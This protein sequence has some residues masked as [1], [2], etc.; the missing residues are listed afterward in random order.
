[1]TEFIL[2][3]I[4]FT[5]QGNWAVSTAYEKDD[6]V[7]YGGNTYVCTTGHTSA[8]IEADFYTDIAKWDVHVEGVTHKGDHATA[9]F[10]KLNDIVKS[11]VSQYICTTQHTST[12]TINLANFTL[13]VLGGD[14]ATQSGKSGQFLSTDGTNTSWVDIVEAAPG[15]L[16]TLNELAASL[17]DDPDFAGTITTALAGKEP[18]LTAG[19]TTQ[20][21]RGDKTWQTL[22]VDPTMGGDMSGTTSNAQIVPGAVDTAEM[23]NDAVNITKLNVT[24]GTSGQA[25]MTDGS[26]T[27]TFGDVDA[28][29]T[30]TSNAGKFLTTDGTDSSWGALSVSAAA[31][32]DQA[33]TATGYFDVPAGTTAQRPGTPLMGNMRYNST[34]GEMEQYSGSGWIG[35]AGSV[36]IIT[37]IGPSTAAETG[38]TI[39]INGANFSGS[40]TVQLIGTDNSVAVP[41]T[42]TFVDVN[43]LSITTPALTVAN[44]PYDVKV[45]N[46]DGQTYTLVNSLDAGGVP[47]WTTAA[48]SIGTMLDVV[49]TPGVT[50]FTLV[51]GDP[52]STAVT[53][54]ETTS[55]LA[56]AGL[57]LNSTT[58]AITG[59]APT[60]Q[61]TN[62]ATTYNFDVEASDGVNT[63]PRS[64]SVT[65]MDMPTGGSSTHVYTSTGQGYRSHVFNSSSSFYVAADI[66][67]DI[68]VVAGGGAGGNYSTTNGNGGGGAG[69]MVVAD[70]QLITSGTHGVTIGGGGS[71]TGGNTHSTGN[72]GSD[73]T[74]V[75]TTNLQAK[76]GGG[77]GTSGGPGPGTNG[78]CGGGGARNYTGG[79]SIQDSQGTQ[80]NPGTEIAVWGFKGGSGSS[81]DWNGSGGGGTGEAGYGYL[82]SGNDSASSG[83]A[84]GGNGGAG[85]ICDLAEGGPS[86]SPASTTRWFAGGGGG[87]GNSSEHAGDGYHGGGRG[88]GTTPQ[89]NNDQWPD[90]VNSTTLGHSNIHAIINTGAGGGGGS[91]WAS[92]IS[93]SGNVYGSGSGASGIIIIRYKSG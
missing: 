80:N 19:T 45:T 57:S 51:A 53:Y 9:T 72:T 8:A 39:T 40:S 25:L 20:Y 55:V 37:S 64:F 47:A 42:V 83:Q 6:I 89:Y 48:G 2:G 56:T 17:A 87:G 49:G 59:D 30:Q 46:P 62:S 68:L 74:F 32:S 33:N 90:E 38:T 77:G 91:Y 54:A 41:Q 26:G 27:M 23:A 71:G 29:P 93:S 36:P 44:E 70:N 66:M 34:T 65:I 76:G 12:A 78:G 58:G 52:D 69:A 13:Y 81:G 75:N 7:K 61:A 60:T 24:D 92:N 5:W 50:H 16:D 31:V 11:G 4:K 84:P 28:L 67:C 1:M 14:V 22:T 18:T 21:Y 79:V 63:T 3:K 10:Y 35:F 43:T 15:A 82:G 88:F 86:A 73:S 85:R